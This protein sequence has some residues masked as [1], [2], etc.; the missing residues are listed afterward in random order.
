[1]ERRLPVH[2]V[3]R[4]GFREQ[5]ARGSE[6]NLGPSNFAQA[7]PPRRATLRDSETIRMAYISTLY[8]LPDYVLCKPL[9]LV[10]PGTCGKLYRHSP[11]PFLI[12]A[13]EKESTM[14]VIKKRSAAG[15]ST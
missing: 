4:L 3:R 15:A 6:T 14:K 1:M 7:Y 9:R 8:P 13:G 10:F 12:A 2:Q 5:T 11:D